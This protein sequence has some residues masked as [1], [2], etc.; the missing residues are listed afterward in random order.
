MD[1]D[2]FVEE[3]IA[4]LLSILAS[5]FSLST[6][7]ALLEGD[8]SWPAP[9]AKNRTHFFFRLEKKY[10]QWD[11]TWNFYHPRKLNQQ[12]CYKPL[13]PVPRKMVKGVELQYKANVFLSEIVQ[14]GLTK[15]GWAFTSRC[16]ND[17]TNHTLSIT[18]EGKIQKWN[19]F[20]PGLALISLTGTRP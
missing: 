7:P 3:I 8:M 5:I 10:K 11:I 14:L 13:G 20:N 2:E 9:P 17:Y 4:V 18:Q 6:F 16:I 12:S 15:Y 19:N 1:T